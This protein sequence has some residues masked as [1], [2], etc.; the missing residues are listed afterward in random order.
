VCVAVAEQKEDSRERTGPAGA[1]RRRGGSWRRGDEERREKPAFS[2]GLRVGGWLAAF[3]S[4]L[5]GYRWTGYSTVCVRKMKI[6][7]RLQNPL[8]RVL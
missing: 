3:C 1:T 5:C 2:P 4:S 8:E 6:S 7:P